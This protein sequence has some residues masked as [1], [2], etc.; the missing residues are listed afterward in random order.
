MR[1]KECE[2]GYMTNKSTSFEPVEVESYY[3]KVTVRL[4]SRIL[5]VQPEKVVLFGFSDNMKWLLRLLQERSITPTLADWREKYLDYDC[6]GQQLISADELED[7]K[8][9]LL[10]VCVEEANDFKDAIRVIYYLGKNK[11]PVIYDRTDPNLPF[12]QEEPYKSISEKAQARAISMISD[13]QLFDLIQFIDK[14][15]DV[16]GDVVEYGSLHGGSGAVIAEAVKHFGEKP[17]WLFDTFDGIPDSKYGLDFH[18]NGSFSDNSYSQVRDAF[19]DMS[20]VKVIKGN[21]CDTYETVTN[22]ISFGYLASDTLESGELLLNFMWPKL[23]PGGII[24]VCDYGSYPNAI[25]LTVYVDEFIKDKGSDAFIFRADKFGI[26][27]MKN[28]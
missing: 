19:S 3:P 1:V 8:N 21:I 26:Y 11:I 24:A 17:V 4:L 10:V 23:S 18:W 14:T 6:G 13:P 22:A 27:I 12:R 15:K 2:E 16:P 20:N 7:D 28:R 25:P 5:E 9:T